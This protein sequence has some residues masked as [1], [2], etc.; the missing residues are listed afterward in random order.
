[1]FTCFHCGHSSSS[2]IT[3]PCSNCGANLNH[4]NG[5]SFSNFQ[6]NKWN[7]H[8]DLI[9]GYQQVQLYDKNWNCSFDTTGTSKINDIVK[10]TINYGQKLSLQS[11]RGNHVNEAYLSFIPE[12]IGQGTSSQYTTLST[13]TCSGCCI[14]SPQSI[15]YGHPF[16]VLIDWVKQT[17]SSESSQCYKCGKKTH[18]GLQICGECYQ[19]I[20]NWEKLL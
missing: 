12:I 20:G 13:V 10:F 1:M 3:Y 14:I 16:P 11:N 18:V 4:L 17:W 5:Q 9:Q 15:N 7:E 19:K 6:R 8:T 2:P